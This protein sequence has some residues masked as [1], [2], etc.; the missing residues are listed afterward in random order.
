VVTGQ[1]SED[2][3]LHATLD[4]VYQAS[5]WINTLPENVRIALYQENRWFYLDR[6]YFWAN[7]GQHNMIVYEALPDGNALVEEYRRF[8]LTHVLVSYQWGPI[9][10]TRWHQLINDAIQRGRL[11]EVFRTDRAERERRGIFVYEVR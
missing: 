3:F 6:P 9:T 8:G 11:V 10:D 1:V 5:E 2:D 4:P 7:P